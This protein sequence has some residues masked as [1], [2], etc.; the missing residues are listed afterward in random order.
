MNGIGL[1]NATIHDSANLKNKRICQDE[2]YL[3]LTCRL[4]KIGPAIQ[5][6]TYHTA[7]I[8]VA[9]KNHSLN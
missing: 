3:F 8:I 6:F 7:T 4:K 2:S 5:S 9:H 1:G